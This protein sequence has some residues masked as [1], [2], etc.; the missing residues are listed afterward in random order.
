MAEYIN[1]EELE[2]ENLICSICLETYTEPK[3]LDCA[4]SFCLS[5]LNILVDKQKSQGYKKHC[6]KCPQCRNITNLPQNGVTGLKTN[7]L[8]NSILGIKKKLPKDR[9]GS[10]VRS[11]KAVA[12][13]QECSVW[14]CYQCRE[15]H[16]MMKSTLNHT[17]L[18]TSGIKVK[19]I[20]L[21]IILI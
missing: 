1:F 12:M 5:C 9:C 8:L 4:H 18:S 13:C 10:C 15:S 16:P 19:Y 3:M 2:Q 20:I 6:I 11:Q 14:L 7:F 21:V 17:I